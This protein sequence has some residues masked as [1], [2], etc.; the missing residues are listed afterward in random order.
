MKRP[1]TEIPVVV[2]TGASAGVGRA[3]AIRFANA[4]A[5]LG[6][7]ARGEEALR[8]MRGE[9]AGATAVA[10]RALDVANAE[11]MF[12]A[13][14]MFEREL[15][16]I[17]IWINDAM[18]TVFSPVREMTPEEF[19]RVTEVTYL[20]FVH[21]CMAALK[22]M[23][24]RNKG[25]IINIGSA[26][27]YRGIPLQS[28]YC[29]AKHAIRGFTSALRSELEHEK[30]GIALTMVQLPA[31]NTPQFDWART[32]MPNR[33]K[34]MGTIYEPE[35]A[36]AAVYRASIKRPKEYW[37]GLSTFMTIIGNMVVPEFMDRF[38]A[39]TA[40]EGQET[41][42][43]V[44]EDR[45]DNLYDPV[46]ALHGTHGHFGADAKSRAF[47]ANGQAA[48]AAVVMAGAAVFFVLGLL[49]PQHG[50]TAERIFPPHT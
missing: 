26:L 47:F 6:L 25:H 11:A 50:R 39:R 37:V 41:E 40:V 15:G 38:L 21:G 5:K 43:P 42:L 29:G 18:V 24:P 3:T 16:P 8:E 46:T 22:H 12:E 20:G 33:P 1:V 19:R 44:R 34:P 7:I 10:H 28:A 48:R 49:L 14:D 17:D 9:L 36:A 13:A 23:R 35:A 27:A 31:M 30:S 32:H 2:I 45:K 4:G